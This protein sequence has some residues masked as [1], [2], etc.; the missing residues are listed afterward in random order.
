MGSEGME[1][2]DFDRL[3]RESDYLRHALIDLLQ[4]SEQSV[5]IVAAAA[6]LQGDP[7]RFAADVLELQQ[8]AALKTPNPT[9]D[10]MLGHVREVVKTIQR[11]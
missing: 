5:A 4:S 3:L 8:D 6:A 2:E 9:R 7:V 11:R 10:R 1:C